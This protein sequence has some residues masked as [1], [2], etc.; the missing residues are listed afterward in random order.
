MV[1]GAV[2]PLEAGGLFVLSGVVGI[3]LGFGFAWLS[4][5]L[6][7]LLP[8]QTSGAATNLSMPFVAYVAAD[9]LHGSGVLAVL[10]YALTL[11]RA[12]DHSGA[13]TRTRA[14]ALW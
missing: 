5:R 10:V 11:R 3:G 6:L 8:A 12:E 9:E 14:A 4:H 2:V 7:D 1:S 13:A